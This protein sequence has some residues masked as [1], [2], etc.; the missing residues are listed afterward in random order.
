MNR[1]NITR[2][3]AGIAVCALALTL[4]LTA[5]N[6]DDLRK[7]KERAETQLR[8][9]NRA[10][11]KN[12]KPARSILRNRPED[13]EQLKAFEWEGF[14]YDPAASRGDRWVFTLG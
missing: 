10:L 14:R 7:N 5:Q 3:I 2:R 6:V 9:T 12:L 11:Q 1:G 13:P 8:E 4:T